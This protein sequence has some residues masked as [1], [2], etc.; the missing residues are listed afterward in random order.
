MRPKL[1]YLFLVFLLINT[2][3]EA[4]RVNLG[5]VIN[6]SRRT[7]AYIVFSPDGNTMYFSRKNPGTHFDIYFSTRLNNQTW[8]SP[9]PL[10]EL[11]NEKPNMVFYIY[12][13]GNRMLVNGAYGEPGICLVTKENGR[14]G[15]PVPLRFEPRAT[16]WGQ[17]NAKL[18]RDGKV[19]ILSYKY[20]ICVSF[21]QPN[22]AWSHPKRL[23]DNINT[24]Y[25]EYTPFLAP[26]DKTLFFSSGGHGAAQND[27]FVTTRLD[28]TWLNWSTPINCG[29]VVNSVDW[30]SYFVIP[31]TG[32]LAYVY[33][34]AEGNG[35]IFSVPIKDLNLG[36]PLTSLKGVVLDK[37]TK[38]P[39]SAE[40]EFIHN[41]DY[42][43]AISDENGNYSLWLPAG[44]DYFVNLRKEGYQPHNETVDLSNV[45]HFQ[46]NRRDFYLSKEKSVSYNITHDEGFSVVYFDFDKDN[47]Q[48][49]SVEELKRILDFAKNDETEIIKIEGHTDSI[50]TEAY[51][52]ALSVRRALSVFKFF[53]DMGVK[54]SKMKYEGFGETRPVA[55][56]DT[57]EGRAKNRRVEIFLK[58]RK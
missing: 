52:M 18:S 39:L 14:W 24:P 1:I 45:N 44:K 27:I 33:S 32:E 41:Q 56:N 6:D 25:Y 31:E 47:P 9:Q 37:Q 21:L 19:M 46:T 35:D 7:E 53:K 42:Y 5:P 20:D 55:P 54:E 51:N 23:P 11:N 26:D 58:E 2:I 4:Q 15:R 28:D 50:G 57:E 34:L 40:L 16:Q 36:N 22:G 17:H 12:P 13:D 30:E 29:S 43:K 10:V 38:K 3:S 8:S 48:Q 49:A